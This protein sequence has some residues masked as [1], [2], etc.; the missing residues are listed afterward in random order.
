MSDDDSA[1]R[2][3]RRAFLRGE[4]LFGGDETDPEADPDADSEATADGTD[5]GD[6]AAT[7]GPAVEVDAIVGRAQAIAGVDGDG[8]DPTP[9][10]AYQQT[11]ANEDEASDD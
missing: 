4:F 3:S 2:M 11:D 6:A 9:H 1:D 10:P 8:S 5:E 7:R